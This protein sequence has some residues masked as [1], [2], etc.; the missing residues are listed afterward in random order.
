M[1]E[2]GKP[3]RHQ[4]QT[5]DQGGDGRAGILLSGRRGNRARSHAGG[6]GIRS[7]HGRHESGSEAEADMQGSPIHEE[8][9]RL[10]VD[11]EATDGWGVLD[12]LEHL[13]AFILESVPP[14]PDVALCPECHREGI[15][16]TGDPQARFA[17]HS[18]PDSMSECPGSETCAHLDF[19][20]ELA[21][22]RLEDSSV[23]SVDVRARCADCFAVLRFLGLDPG[24][25][26]ATPTTSIWSDVA[27]L[28]VVADL[29]PACWDKDGPLTD[30][31]RAAIAAALER[32]VPEG[33]FPAFTVRAMAA[34]VIAFTE[35]E[36][37]GLMEAFGDELPA[38]VE[39]SREELLDAAFDRLFPKYVACPDCL[40][41]CTMMYP[42]GEDSCSACDGGGKIW[43]PE[44][45]ENPP[46]ATEKPS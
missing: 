17:I 16:L 43:N 20:G 25:S 40:G 38:A 34:P 11:D 13:E 7:H 26:P 3:S 24:L 6:G 22:Q 29:P 5:T 15:Q 2:I 30:D 41:T 35:P 14:R 37:Q 4:G 32:G 33:G 44:R 18:K 19:H 10:L 9:R 23:W 12:V 36:L 46:W 45:P 39:E 8:I 1:D 27:S 31:D 42:R 28:P 21:V